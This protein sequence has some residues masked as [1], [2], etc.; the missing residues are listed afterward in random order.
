DQDVLV[1][2]GGDSALETAIALT[3]CGAKITLSYRKGEFSRPKPE[4][5]EHLK[6]LVAHPDADVS[7]ET[8][9]SE[10]VTTSAGGFLGKDKK[11]GKINL[12]MKSEV[13][14]IDEKEVTLVNA[15]NEEVTIPNDA[16]F[17]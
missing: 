16:V 4:N 15:D 9:V 10:R 14:R 5:L 8:P 6:K 17:T 13:K 1:V 2:G 3:Q 12:M 11:S 7:V